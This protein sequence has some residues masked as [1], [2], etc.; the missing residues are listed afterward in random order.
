M[1]HDNLPGKSLHNTK[2]AVFN[3]NAD[4]REEENKKTADLEF[5]YETV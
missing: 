4:F 1:F 5:H 2:D 3:S